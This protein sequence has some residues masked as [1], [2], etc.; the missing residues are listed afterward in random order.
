MTRERHYFVKRQKADETSECFNNIKD[1][2][3]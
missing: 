3:R 1:W 2:V